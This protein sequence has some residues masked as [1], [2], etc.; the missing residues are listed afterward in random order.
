[1]DRYKARISLHGND[2]RDRFKETFKKNIYALANDSL[3]LKKVKI[4]GVDRQIFVNSGT[5][6]YYKEIQSLPD[7]K[8]YA[9]EIVE[10]ANSHWLID[11]AD[12]DDEMYVD[13]H[14]TQCTY[15]LRWLNK[16]GKVIERWTVKTNASAYNSGYEGDKVILTGYDQA[17][18]LV[19][20]DPETI[21]LKRGNRFFIDN[22]LEN[23]TVYRV[24]RVDTVSH[25]YNGRG[26]LK[27]ICTEE[28]IDRKRD[29][30]ELMLCDYFVPEDEQLNALQINSKTKYII[31]G[32]SI[33][34]D[35]TALDVG[36]DLVWT[37]DCDFK[38]KLVVKEIEN[39]IN[40]STLDDS[41][42][43]KT[44]TITLSCNDN[45]YQ[46]DVMNVTIIGGL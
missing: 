45:S 25:V 18:L 35:F 37:V 34:T 41:L 46:N 31:S 23:P 26:Y 33:G 39:G 38:D 19:E 44:L 32:L 36:V 15:K 2:R 24:T 16:N 12:N 21:K 22:D 43:G 13:G 3:S 4:S 30:V 40:I 1:M 17:M 11:R 6:P 42:I 10:W 8:F 20:Y 5:Q 27:L 28:Q 9:G 7:D 29:N 14:M